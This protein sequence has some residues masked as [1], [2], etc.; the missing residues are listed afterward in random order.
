[1]KLQGKSFQNIKMKENNILVERIKDITNIMVK[2]R[3]KL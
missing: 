1:M 3:G 2:H